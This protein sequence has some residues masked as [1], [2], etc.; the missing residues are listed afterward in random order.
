MISIISEITNPYIPI[1]KNDKTLKDIILIMQPNKV[2]SMVYLDKF[3]P[4]KT[5]DNGPSI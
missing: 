4:C 1:L 5:L 2:V 3:N